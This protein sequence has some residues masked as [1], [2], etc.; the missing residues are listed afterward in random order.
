MV[1]NTSDAASVNS[2]LPVISRRLKAM[3]KLMLVQFAESS[4]EQQHA[5]FELNSQC[6]AVIMINATI[7]TS[8][9]DNVLHMDGTVTDV[10]TSVGFDYQFAAESAC[11]YLLGKGH[12]KIALLVD[13]L[14]QANCSELLSGYKNTIQNLSLPYDRRLVIEAKQ[15]PEQSL[16]GLINSFTQYSA[17]VVKR[18]IYAAEAMCL[19]RQFNIQVPKYV[20]VISLEDSP[21]AQQLNPTLTCISHS[22]HQLAQVCMDNLEHMLEKT[23]LKMKD[24]PLLSGRLICC[25]SVTDL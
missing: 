25:E 6:E 11:R 23:S 2:H 18:D 21:L 14:T 19:M 7:N 3:N 5:L 20:S 8:A 24:S 4:D 17:I 10:Q 22:S 15:N 12:R 9:F 13:D 1:I 16:L